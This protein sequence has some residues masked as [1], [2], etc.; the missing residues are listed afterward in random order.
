MKEIDR[1]SA[2]GEKGRGGPRL[3][4]AESLGVILIASFILQAHGGTFKPPQAVYALIVKTLD[5]RGAGSRSEARF[6]DLLIGNRQVRFII[7]QS[8]VRKGF[9]S[10]A[11]YLLDAG[12]VTARG[13]L[14]GRMVSGALVSG[15]YRR[16]RYQRVGIVD[17][18]LSGHRAVV[19]AQGHI[20]KFPQL[21]ISTDFTITPDASQLTMKT[22]IVNRRR[23]KI[24]IR[25][26]ELVRW[27]NSYTF[28]PGR[29]TRLRPKA[30]NQQPIRIDKKGRKWVLGY[31]LSY[32]GWWLG[33]PG[34]ANSYAYMMPKGKLVAALRGD[35]Q[36]TK[37][38]STM[39]ICAKF[40]PLA[41]EQSAL[42][43]RQ[44]VVG[45]GDVASLVRQVHRLRGLDT[46]SV[47]GRVVERNS[48]TGVT[49][50]LVIARDARGPISRTRSGPDGRFRMWLPARKISLRAGKYGWFRSEPVRLQVQAG[51]AYPELKLMLKPGAMI[52]YEVR[53]RDSAELV[54]A[55]IIIKRLGQGSRYRFLDD[56]ESLYRYH[57]VYSQKG[58]GRIS[59]YPG[60]YSLTFTRGPEYSIAV[61]KIKAVL[62]RVAVVKGQL[63]RVVD[64]R[65]YVSAD[66]HT[67]CL[68][69]KDSLMGLVERVK[70][71]AA[72]NIEYAVASDH[73]HLTDLSPVIRKLGLGKYIKSAIG[74]EVTMGGAEL[75]HFNVFPL[76]PLGTFRG[77]GA[78]P[79]FWTNPRR[80]FKA[81]R[82]RPGEKVIIVNHPR[83]GKGN[84]YFNQIGWIG[85][86]A[87]S[88]HHLYDGGYDALEVMSGLDRNMR[89]AKR[90]LSEWFAMLNR[91]FK[92]TALGNSDSHRR[93]I[94]EVGYPRNFIRIGKDNPRSIDDQ[95]IVRALK[96][97]RVVVSNGPFITMRAGKAEGAGEGDSITKPPGGLRLHIR[98]Q[99]PRWIDVRSLTLYGN[100]RRIFE[101]RLGKPWSVVRSDGW[102]RVNP[103]KDTWYVAVAR[104]LKPM[105]VVPHRKA[106]PL[107]FTNPIWVDADGDGKFTPPGIRQQAVK[108]GHKL[109]LKGLKKKLNHQGDSHQ[110]PSP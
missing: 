75:G 56:R 38:N 110:I 49:N 13:D 14:L 11:G 41:P 86:L 69:S 71:L 104:G 91:G 53:D 34:L 82:E 33:R 99:A 80:I 48:L 93:W 74:N 85:R 1:H 94:E 42:F 107:A 70:S 58:Q 17:D 73:N 25:P 50:S 28:F 3:T 106:R 51:Q 18:G 100:G 20:E 87:R 59:L 37:Y 63:E 45:N 52:R 96:A 64:T 43:H 47:G 31:T 30:G 108:P 60:P 81:V 101:A 102:I 4:L 89:W 2:S 97:H 62:G 8:D 88:R 46:M 67:H 109:D 35:H 9:P 39:R 26:C 16:A 84:G 7:G 55:R 77:N 5:Q 79:Y 24:H 12:L 22:T 57:I 68:N 66:L 15:K 40:S 83:Q 21:E 76:S 105:P 19:R 72:E 78:I 65:G 61:K 95:D 10:R 29:G 103:R 23:R 6:G 27:G 36:G 98:V 44:L 90:L 32:R 92:Y 54:P